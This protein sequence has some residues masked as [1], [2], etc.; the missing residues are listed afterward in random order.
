MRNFRP[1]KL[2]L[3]LLV[4]SLVLAGSTL[5][6][7][8]AGTT[9]SLA[10]GQNHVTRSGPNRE[11]GNSSQSALD[12]VRVFYT[13]IT[14]YQPLGLPQGRAKKDL[15]PLLSKRLVRELDALQSCDD[16]YYRRYGDYL[17]ANQF[18]PVTPWLE[19]GLFS[20]PNEAPIP[21]KFSILGSETVGE[22]RVDVHLRFTYKQTHC[23]GYPTQ[24]E[25]YEGV[26]TVILENGRFVVDDF[27]AMDGTKSINRLSDGYPE[28]KVGR[29][30]GRPD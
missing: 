11:N 12:A 14:K 21:S 17:R 22:N 4:S 24:Y 5:G 26:V 23:C 25:Y 29:W 8:P 18:K 19:H 7:T 30:V 28:C 6:Q 15:W 10:Q 9:P 27:V 2:P 16:D 1:R 20:G 13:Y 3:R